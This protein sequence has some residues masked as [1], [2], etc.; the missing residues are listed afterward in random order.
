MPERIPIQMMRRWIGGPGAR[1]RCLLARRDLLLGWRSAPSAGSA[2]VEFSLTVPLLVIV[3]LGAADYGT[4]AVQQAVLEGATRAG[5]EYARANCT[6]TPL[7]STPCISG[8]QSAVCG[9]L[10]LTLTSSTCSPV[11][12]GVSPVCTC[13]DGSSVDCTTGTCSVGTPPDTRVFK[14]V[15]VT[16]TQ[17]FTPLFTVSNFPGPAPTTFFLPSS[18][19]AT[20]VTRIQ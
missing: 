10:E 5:A 14:Y 2:A 7:T 12:P 13:V 6:T 17:T 16:A 18:L 11:T 8:T 19:S 1:L 4:M 15:S 20:T 3:A 9:H